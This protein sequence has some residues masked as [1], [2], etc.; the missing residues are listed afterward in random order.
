MFDTLRLWESIFAHDDRTSYTNF[1][2]LA[3]LL[4]VREAIAVLDYS[5][6]MALLKTISEKV[7]LEETIKLA[8]QLYTTYHLVDLTE[9]AEKNRSRL[10]R[11]KENGGGGRLKKKKKKFF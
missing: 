8:D 9:L 5:Q 6:I 2:A 10:S 3:L 1:F 11:E 7:K 4:S